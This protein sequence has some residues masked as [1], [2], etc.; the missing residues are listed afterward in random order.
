MGMGT[1]INE[2]LKNC[3]IKKKKKTNGKDLFTRVFIYLLFPVIEISLTAHHLKNN[4]FKIVLKK[5]YRNNVVN[6]K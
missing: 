1:G 2:E 4:D 3:K 5:R 6:N